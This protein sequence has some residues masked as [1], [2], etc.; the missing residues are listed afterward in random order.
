MARP[1]VRELSP[2]DIVE[3]NSVKDDESIVKNKGDIRIDVLV[4]DDGCEIVNVGKV[5]DS[6][7]LNLEKERREGTDTSHT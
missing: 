5:N 4:D 1:K 3:V 2:S 7:D 6:F